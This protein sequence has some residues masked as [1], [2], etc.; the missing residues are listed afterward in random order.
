MVCIIATG[1]IAGYFFSFPVLAALTCISIISAVHLFLKCKEMAVIIAIC[2]TVCT[3]IAN[4]VMW[5]T[6]YIVTQ[7][8]WF[9][10][11]VRTHIFR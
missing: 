1:F 4:T 8:T 3:I 6:H 2:F 9:G 11:F 5:V 7:Q 10:D